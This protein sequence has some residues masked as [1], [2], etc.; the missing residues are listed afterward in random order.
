[1]TT[2]E[3]PQMFHTT[4]CTGTE[5]RSTKK[6]DNDTTCS[7]LATTTLITAAW[8]LRVALMPTMCMLVAE[9]KSLA[10]LA[11]APHSHTNEALIK[12][13]YC[14]TYGEA[15]GADEREKAHDVGVGLRQQTP[16]DSWLLLTSTTTPQLSSTTP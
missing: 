4:V 5:P 7:A 14:M 15:G 9:A 10:R 8:S 12:E 11:T 1:M 16:R 2:S 6:L 13:S 3:V